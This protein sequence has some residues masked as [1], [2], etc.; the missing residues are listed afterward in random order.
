MSDLKTHYAFR[1]TRSVQHLGQ[2][3]WQPICGLADTF[4]IRMSTELGEVTCKNCQNNLIA[5]RRRL[6][7][8]QQVNLIRRAGKW[9][10]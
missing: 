3:V 6:G 4:N 1:V 2:T 10:D 8:M 7:I 9:E 5:N